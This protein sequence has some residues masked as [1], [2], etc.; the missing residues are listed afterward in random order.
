MPLVLGAERIFA[1][2]CDFGGR[3][4]FGG[5]VHAEYKLIIKI[6][7]FISVYPDKQHN[8][9]SNQKWHHDESNS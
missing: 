7:F 4:I 9:Q 2:I 1:L 3:N 5:V 6:S 8:D